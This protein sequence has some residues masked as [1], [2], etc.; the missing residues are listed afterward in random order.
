MSVLSVSNTFA[1][2]TTAF[3]SEVNTNFSDILVW[4]NGNISNDN[5]TTLTGEVSWSIS[6]DV[7]AIDIANGGTEGSINIAQ[8]GVLD[9]NKSALKVLASGAQTT[10]AAAL[11]VSFT[12]ASTI[13]L[14]KLANSG[15]GFGIDYSQSGIL[16]SS[17]SGLRV[18]SSTN[19]VNGD[20][21]VDFDLSS[22]SS[23]IPVLRTMYNSVEVFGA[24]KA[25]ATLRKP[26]VSKTFSD[27]PYAAATTDDTILVDASSGATEVDLPA[28]ATSSGV[29]LTIRKTDTSVNAVTIDPNSSETINGSATSV[30]LT[31]QYDSITLLCDGSGWVITSRVTP[32]YKTGTSAQEG[33]PASGAYQAF[34]GAN[35][36]VALTPGTW[37]IDGYFLHTRTGGSTSLTAM[38]AYWASTAGLDTSTPPTLI[39][40]TANVTL[41]WGFD[42]AYEMR[43]NSA[44]DVDGYAG[45]V[46]RIRITNTAAI[47]LYLVPIAVYGAGTIEVKVSVYARKIA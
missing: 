31:Q 18:A 38:N 42:N 17:K 39:S 26:I 44:Q 5:L 6:S 33:M 11:D 47:T 28:A 2:N 29:Q 27:T 43:L 16:A 32:S 30:S 22:A 40:A 3:A 13:P 19:Q 14:V 7:F 9:S 41:D 8:S 4:A 34:T 37:E 35:G 23:T 36:S 20:A 21:L 46:G 25:G 15:T 24:R 12:G 45:P 1:A 10:G